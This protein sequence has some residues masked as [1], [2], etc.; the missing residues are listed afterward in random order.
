[1]RGIRKYAW[2][3]V[4]AITLTESGW[5]ILTW[6][7]YVATIVMATLVKWHDTG[8][9]EKELGHLHKMPKFLREKMSKLQVWWIPQVP[10]KAFTVEVN[11]IVEGVKIMDVLADYDDF[12][13]KNKIKPDYCN[14]GGLQEWDDDC[15][16]EGTPGWID[17][18]D[19]ETGID[20]PEEWLEE[21]NSTIPR[22]QE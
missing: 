18:Y 4:F 11:S 10:G 14:V 2:C 1:M 21:F 5:D 17:W 22:Q 3:V 20:D 9:E 19:E 8:V 13:F 16:G 6:Q 12:Q 7:F 15:D